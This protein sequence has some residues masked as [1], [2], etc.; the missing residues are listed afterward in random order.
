VVAQPLLYQVAVA[1]LVAVAAVDQLLAW[2]SGAVVVLVLV[3]VQRVLG[4]VAA[5]QA[6][7]H[8]AEP[9]PLP[10]RGCWGAPT[11]VPC[12]PP[13]LRTCSGSRQRYVFS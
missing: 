7:V 10:G 4:L 13:C 11:A 1:V 2:G 8:L 3:V 12:P 6:P 9:G 5:P